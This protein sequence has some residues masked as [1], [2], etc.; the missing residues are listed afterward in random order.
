MP[1]VS[2]KPV[3]CVLGIDPSLTGFALSVQYFPT[4]AKYERSETGRT[5]SSPA[6]S[7]RERVKRYEQILE[8]V[9]ENTPRLCSVIVIEGYSHGS[10]MSMTDL[11]ELGGILRQ[12][13]CN[14]FPEAKLYEVQPTSL[15][16]FITGNGASKGKT[17]VIAAI[18][19]KYGMQFDTDD[20]YDAYGLGKVAMCLAGY[21]KPDNRVQEEVINRI[22][23]PPVKKPKRRSK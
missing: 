21:I 1:K 7:V 14:T 6:K 22:L 20:E 18:A 15:K 17:G 4:S 12:W 2:K 5:T 9:A 3:G 10:R 8:W 16:K 13:L 23:H 19:K 11:S